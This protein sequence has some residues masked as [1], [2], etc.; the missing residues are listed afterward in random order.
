VGT[1]F[2]AASVAIVLLAV[3]L[4]GRGP[5]VDDAVAA[6][7]QAATVS[8][9]AAERS[10]TAVVRITHEG[11]L[12][13]DSTIKWNGKDL[14]LINDAPD[15]QGRVGTRFLLVDGMM[16]GE[17]AEA[18]GWVELGR[19][20]SIDPGSGTTP[21]EY[22]TA[23]REDVGGVTLRRITGGMQGLTTETLHDGSTV[24]RGAVPAGLVARETGFKEGQSIRVLPFGYVAHDRASDPEAL[25]DAAI[26]VG[27]DGIVREINVNWPG[28]SYTVS[29]GDLG[30]TPQPVAPENAKPL[31]R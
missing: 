21:D 29:Y 10:G 23:L 25:L 31:R 17:D 15:R 14:A 22:L 30:E 19:P 26:T 24:Y 18:G 20:D 16:Y 7:Q 27:A 9:A 8:A 6:V 4:S 2:A 11:E 5:A 12:W 13:A 3:D 28:W 1:L